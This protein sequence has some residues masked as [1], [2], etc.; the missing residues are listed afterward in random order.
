ML[1]ISEDVIKRSLSNVELQWGKLPETSS[2]H[3]IPMQYADMTHLCVSICSRDLTPSK[4]IFHEMFVTSQSSSWGIAVPWRVHRNGH[5]WAIILLR[6]TQHVAAWTTQGR[7]NVTYTVTVTTNAWATG[8][9]SLLPLTN[10]EWS[11][12]Q[13]SS[14]TELGSGADGSLSC[15]LC[16]CCAALTDDRC[17]WSWRLF[18]LSPHKVQKHTAEV[19]FNYTD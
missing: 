10:P 16:S 17:L 2:S 3:C 12:L 14:R 13:R 15:D 9:A 6:A 19:S 18:A 4:S 1:S 8:C 7:A 5:G 11:Q